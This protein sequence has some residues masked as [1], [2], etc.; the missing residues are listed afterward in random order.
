MH[1]I[2]L[3][4]VS[5]LLSMSVTA[6]D[7]SSTETGR[8]YIKAGRMLDAA[9]GRILSDRVI[10][11]A[12]DRV[13]AVGDG[14]TAIPPD[15]QV[16]D[17]SDAFVLP[18]LIDM[19]THL[20]GYVDSSYFNNYFLSPH[21]AVIGGVAHAERTLMA[22]FTTVRNVGAADY[23]DVALRD[24]IDA[25][26]VPGPRLRVS[27]PGLGITGGHCDE[28]SLNHSFGERADG[29]AD[30]PWA[31]REMVRRNVKYGVDLIKFCATGDRSGRSSLTPS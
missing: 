17:L 21:R 30:G 1:R 13:E 29:V 26:E 4:L 14:G 11:I 7:Q 10:T 3:L 9:S 5:V 6:S 31:V 24:S 20:L 22:G 27:G 8:T 18:G 19:H 15:A 23:Q 16:I 25:G 28:N 12:G 2:A